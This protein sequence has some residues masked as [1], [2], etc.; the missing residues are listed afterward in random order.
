MST[1]TSTHDV[2]ERIATA[3]RPLLVAFGA[4]WCPPCRTLDPVLDELAAK[5]PDV[6][7]VNAYGQTE[8]AP[9]ASLLDPRYQKPGDPKRRSIGRAAA[10]I[11]ILVMLNE[12]EEAP[13]G[14]PGEIWARGPNMMTGYWKK[15]DETAAALVNGWVRTGDIA[16]M[17]ED[18]F[19]YICDRAK[20]MI[21]SGGENVFSAEVESA[22]LRHPA[23]RQAAVIGV[24]DNL[25]GERVHAVLVG[26]PGAEPSQEELY[27]H[28]K[29]LIAGYKCPRSVEYRESLPMSGAGKVLKRELRAPYWETEAAGA[30]RF[31]STSK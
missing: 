20:D 16:I 14:T 13:R 23:I 7:L 1:T 21:I 25:Y 26:E 27:A 24:P 10:S 2:L 8:L 17:D 29:T 28:C 12:H 9:L 15:P 6:R 30:G 4:A 11:E 31:G 5:L 19:L 3:E 22:L 18:G